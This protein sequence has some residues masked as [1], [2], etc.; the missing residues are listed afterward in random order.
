[1]HLLKLTTTQRPAR[2]RSAPRRLEPGDSALA[3]GR[4][5]D[6]VTSL[7]SRSDAGRRWTAVAAPRRRRHADAIG[8]IRT[9]GRDGALRGDSGAAPP[10]SAGTT[11]SEDAAAKRRGR[12]RRRSTN[13][14]AMRQ[15][16]DMTGKIFR[17]FLLAVR[18]L[19]KAYVSPCAGASFI[20]RLA[21][22]TRAS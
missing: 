1:M 22:F 20:R 13:T 11:R 5:M 7:R 6:G 3:R 18:A 4:P 2:A 19:G 14:T 8:A 21:S 15:R 10:P 9:A 16:P 17:G 12:G